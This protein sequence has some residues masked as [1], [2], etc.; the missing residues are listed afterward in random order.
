MLKLLFLS[1]LFFWGSEFVTPMIAQSSPV[2]CTIDESGTDDYSFQLFNCNYSRS[3]IDTERIS[4]QL[5]TNL[6]TLIILKAQSGAE[7]IMPNP[8]Q[9][10]ALIQTAWVLERAEQFNDVME[11]TL[12]NQETGKTVKIDVSF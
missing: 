10:N 1:L 6:G 11:L 4:F 9:V 2:S 12:Y 7:V 3:Q 8:D 5:S